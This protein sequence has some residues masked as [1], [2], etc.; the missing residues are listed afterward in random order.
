MGMCQPELEESAIFLESR[1]VNIISMIKE[2]ESKSENN[3]FK[4]QTSEQAKVKSKRK[5]ESESIFFNWSM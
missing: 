1:K 2:C 5:S 4:F 3:L